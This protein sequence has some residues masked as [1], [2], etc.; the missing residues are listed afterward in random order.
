MAG[1]FLVLIAALG[2][3]KPAGAQALTGTA[4]LTEDEA[5]GPAM[6]AGIDRYLMRALE[7]SI[8]G[9]AALWRRDLSSHAAYTASV[10]VNRERFARIV[11]VVD[12]R[13]DAALQM[14]A[15]AGQPAELGRGPGYTAYTVSWK[16][17]R[18]VVAEGILLEPDA[19]PKANVI[20]LPDCDWTP[21]AVSG[22]A[23]GVPAEAQFA[24]R[25]AEGGCRVLVPTLIDRR[26]TYSGTPGIRMT[27]QPHREFIY[28]AAYQMGRH[29]IGYEVQEV[30]AAVDWFAREADSLPVGVAGYGEGG[31]VAL[32]AA[33]VDT[34]IDAALISGYFGPRERV[35]AEPIYRNV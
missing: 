6:V 24:R 34:R 11:G 1:H 29:V 35:W 14:Q 32:Y 17:F 5:L 16:V 30:L 20:A 22:L 10:Q 25:L 4:P 23:P 31:L 26:D 19:A 12:A 15:P 7:D 2:A 18:G 3:G 13:D 21:E 8:T 27:N 33:A 9:R 28:R